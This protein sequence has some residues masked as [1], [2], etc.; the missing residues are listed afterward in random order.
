ML[1][2]AAPIQKKPVL[3]WGSLGGWF[4]TTGVEFFPAYQ[5]H[6]VKELPPLLFTAAEKERSAGHSA[7]QI[8]AL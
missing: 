4:C 1:A 2:G 5:T 6:E 8:D 3:L 7:L